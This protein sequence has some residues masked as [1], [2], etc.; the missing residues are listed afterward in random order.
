MDF[1]D[2]A[3]DLLQKHCSHKDVPR[4]YNGGGSRDA[5]T[6]ASQLG[7]ICRS[8]EQRTTHE[9]PSNRGWIGQEAKELV[10]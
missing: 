10:A 9:I 2:L 4:I 5:A 7:I 8:Y 6:H 1:E 3:V